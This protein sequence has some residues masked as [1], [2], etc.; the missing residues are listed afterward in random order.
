MIRNANYTILSGDSTLTALT[1][2]IS[3]G[4]ANQEDAMPYVTFLVFDTDPNPTKDTLSETDI[5]YVSVSCIGINNLNVVAIAEAVRGALDGYSGTV[6]STVIESSDF[7]KTRDSW[8]QEA[9]A[10]QLVVEFQMFV[11]Q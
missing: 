2:R 4:F 11:K 7:Q 3:H 8:I 5:V 6:D 1:S 10:F 9:K